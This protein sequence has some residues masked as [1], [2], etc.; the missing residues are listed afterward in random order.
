M[1]SAV[2]TLGLVPTDAA[3]SHCPAN[4]ATDCSKKARL[5]FS[6]ECQKAVQRSQG[7]G[8]EDRVETQPQSSPFLAY[9]FPKNHNKYPCCI[10]GLN[11]SEY[12]SPPSP[13][14][15][16]FQLEEVSETGVSRL[17]KKQVTHST[18][19]GG[20]RTSVPVCALHRT[21]G[22]TARVPIHNLHTVTCSLIPGLRHSG[23]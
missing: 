4:R 2:E 9:G 10:E 19:R 1:A 20:T 22:S 5:G 6:S 16:H 7:L 14:C 8:R 17:I 12:Y 13:P 11:L 23:F 15:T 21:T 3:S 18:D